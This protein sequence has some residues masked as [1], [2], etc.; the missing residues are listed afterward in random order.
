MDAK[1]RAL[2]VLGKTLQSRGYRFVPV[3]PATHCRILNR[4]LGQNT[5]ESIFGWN[6]P[7]EREGLDPIIFDLLEKADALKSEAGR[8]K[9]RAV[10][11]THLRAHE[12]DSY[13]VCR[14]LL[15]K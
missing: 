1:S 14:L 6:R 11:Y 9:S 3:T 2:T 7:F 5:L 10:S 15:E 12:T 8:F 13:L 4:P